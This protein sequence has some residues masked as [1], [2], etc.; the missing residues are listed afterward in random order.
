MKKSIQSPARG[1][2]A[3]YSHQVLQL[4]PGLGVRVSTVNPTAW[5]LRKK[6]PAQLAET[7]RGKVSG[8]SSASAARLRDTFS[9]WTSP[10]TDASVLPSQQRPG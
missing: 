7:R 5:A 6:Q 4:R 3:N 1:Q 2:G 9:S 8:F 10:G